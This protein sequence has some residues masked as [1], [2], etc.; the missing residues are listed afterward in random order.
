MLA[1]FDLPQLQAQVD[2][3]VKQESAPDFYEDMRQ[4]K[5]KLQKKAE[6]VKKIETI[7]QI[8][9]KLEYFKDLV[10]SFSAEELDNIGG[11][12]EEFVALQK[13]VENLYISTLYNGKFDDE[14]CL[15][16]I[17]S[18]AG[19][20]EAQDWAE[21]L[22]RMYT[23]YGQSKG[24]L[25]TMVDSLAGDGAGYKSVSIMIEGNKAYGNLFA[26]KGVHRLVR[27][28]PFDANKRRHTSF[29]SVD[30]SPLVDD[31]AEIK[32]DPQDLKIDTYRSGG[33]G[34]QHV[35]KTESAVRITHL[36]T[37]IVVQCQ[38]ERSQLQ[39]KELALKMLSSKLLQKQEAEKAAAA[40]KER[41]EAKKIE[42]GS[43]IRSYVLHPY[44]M[45][46]DH[47]TG[48]ETSSSTAVLDG[49]LDIFIEAQLIARSQNKI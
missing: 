23:R 6:I 16:E 17:H 47:R 28:S 12:E 37:G 24:Y 5:Q 31:T 9:A 11:T 27:I 2:N 48:V 46:K 42:W 3:I 30:V 4:A 29:A 8:K 39:N 43:Q 13:Q 35:N 7:N 20:E 40:A 18:G 21:M 14:N 25:V 33:A 26:E 36:P 45:V 15:I 19:G 49:E 22:A 38:N 32:I 44:N 10:T 34:G 41:G 1:T